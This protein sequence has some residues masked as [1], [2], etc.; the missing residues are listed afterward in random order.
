MFINIKNKQYRE[1]SLKMKIV[2]YEI[3][4]CSIFQGFN[5][6]PGFNNYSINNTGTI[7]DRKT[8]KEIKPYLDN[9]KKNLTYKIRLY[10]PLKGS[11]T[12]LL[13]RLVYLSFVDPNLAEKFRIFMKDNDHSNL[14]VD[15]L[16]LENTDGDN[17]KITQP[18]KS[19]PIIATNVFTG[20]RF[21]FVTICDFA[22]AVNISKNCISKSLKNIAQ[23]RVTYNG[24]MFRY[25][26][27]KPVAIQTPYYHMRIGNS[28]RH[29]RVTVKA[30]GQALFSS[31][32][33]EIERFTGNTLSIITKR[34][35]NLSISVEGYSWSGDVSDLHKCPYMK[36]IKHIKGLPTQAGVTIDKSY[37]IRTRTS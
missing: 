18:N 36:K 32:K 21:K 29:N 23:P 3:R 24:F 17:K 33:N 37:K 4:P 10:C 2:R 9:S 31:C 26:D 20:E 5:V 16:S 6:I 30:D 7:I 25:M 11:K 19:R 22:K 27:E 34:M 12:F 13:P 15:N 28:N 14:A 1:F 8:R 35:D